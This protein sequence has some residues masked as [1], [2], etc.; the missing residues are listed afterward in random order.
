MDKTCSI[1]QD[2]LPLYAEDMLRP[3]TKEYVEAHLAACDICKAERKKISQ[4]AAAEVPLAPLRGIRKELRR[5]KLTAVLL[6]AVL[7]LTVATSGFAY[8]TAPQYLPLD[9]LA[10]VCLSTA[11]DG[12]TEETVLRH[13]AFS[14]GTND[15]AGVD[16][17][18]ISLLTPVS[19]MK[20]EQSYDENGEVIYC[21]TAWRTLLD[22]WLGKYTEAPMLAVGDDAIG[23]IAGAEAKTVIV[24]ESFSQA[25]QLLPSSGIRT[26][27]L[28]TRDCAGIY[29]T[30]NDGHD[31][32]LLLG[33]YAG[34]DMVGG[35]MITLPR[36]ALGYYLLLALL[37]AAV[38]GSLWVILRRKK[39]GTALS[40]L[41]PVPL[42][43]AAGHFA[44]K[45]FDTMSYN[46]MRDF[47][48]IVLAGSLIYCAALLGKSLLRGKNTF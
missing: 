7:A 15:L 11:E 27:T 36:L 3:E 20:A 45:G 13:A 18:Q 43:Y 22:D 42:C 30:P 6:A 1:V 46:I 28:D 16:S 21:I 2:L 17:V 37:S 25:E 12:T 32:T 41:A 14:A 38:L 19:G 33:Q 40:Y 4:P 44:V 34:N 47:A 9:E 24:T 23:V 8:L 5:R 48:L 26:I 31:N 29:Y 35:G 39:A 10:F